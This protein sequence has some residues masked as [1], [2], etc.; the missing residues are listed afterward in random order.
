[1][2]DEVDRYTCAVLASTFPSLSAPPYTS[3]PLSPH[4]SLSP[5][6]FFHFLLVYTFPC[7]KLAL[8][9][10]YILVKGPFPTTP[11]KKM[12]FVPKMLYKAVSATTP[13]RS[14]SHFEVSG[15]T[16]GIF[17]SSKNACIDYDLVSGISVLL[18]IPVGVWVY[19]LHTATRPYINCIYLE[20]RLHS[21]HMRSRILYIYLPH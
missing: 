8:F 14:L 20:H 21:W 7:V 16:Q 15:I 17:F 12:A 19:S 2:F 10:P 11:R 18:P 4:L 1:M 13:E 3:L 5:S 6:F 9:I